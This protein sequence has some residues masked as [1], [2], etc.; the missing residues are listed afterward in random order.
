M[1]K[2]VIFVDFCR[3]LSKKE[4]EH[5]DSSISTSDEEFKQPFHHPFLVKDRPNIVLNIRV[6][7]P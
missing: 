7:K 2:I 6:S 5:Y 4:K 1:N 3:K